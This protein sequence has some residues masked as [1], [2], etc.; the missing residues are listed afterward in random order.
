M[1]TV[2]FEST[3]F[4]QIHSNTAYQINQAS[5]SIIFSI[6]KISHQRLKV[7]KRIKTYLFVYL[8]NYFFN[9]N[10]YEVNYVT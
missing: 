5:V 6:T 2:Y 9:F 7:Y 4:L 1:L 10:N 8:Y 3:R